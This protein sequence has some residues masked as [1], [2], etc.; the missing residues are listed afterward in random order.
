MPRALVVTSACCRGYLSLSRTASMSKGCLRPPEIP[1]ERKPLL[2]RMDL[3]PRVCA[4]RAPS[5]WGRPTYP[6]MPVIGTLTTGFS[7][8]PTILGTEHVR[9]GEV[10]AEVLQRW[11]R[12]CRHWNLAAI[13]LARFASP[14]PFA[15]VIGTAPA[16]PRVRVPDIFPAPPCQ[17]RLL[18]WPFKAHRPGVPQTSNSLCRLAPAQRPARTPRGASQS[19]SSP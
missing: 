18:P 7:D 4:E 8:V 3:S 11:P 14:Q 5:S 19:P 13:S 9:R 2:P 10:L 16:R 17:I 15:A 6:H 12:A 1:K